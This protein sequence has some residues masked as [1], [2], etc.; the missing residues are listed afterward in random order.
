M[1]D[2][3]KLQ[4]QQEII[5]KLLLQR[6][7][8]TLEAVT[9]FGKTYTAILWYQELCRRA[10][11][12]L[13]LIVVVPYLKLVND[14]LDVGTGHIDRHGLSRGKVTV[15]T[16]NS[17][18]RP[19]AYHTADCFIFD[20]VH[21]YLSDDA[22][23]WNKAIP[24]SRATYRLALSA[25]LTSEEKEKLSLLG[26]PVVDQVT[27]H[28]A[29]QQ[30]YVADYYVFNVPLYLG[31]VDE[32]EYA[33]LDRDFKSG[34]RFFNFDLD[35]IRYCMSFP[36]AMDYARKTHTS[37]EVVRSKAIRSYRAMNARKTFLYNNHTKL[38]MTQQLVQQFPDRRIIVFS[39]SIDFVNRLSDTLGADAVAYHSALMGE[40][41]QGDKLLARARKVKEKGK[42]V[43]RYFELGGKKGYTANELKRMY[44]N[45]TVVGPASVK[46]RAIDRFKRGDARILITATALDEGADI[47][48]IDM[49]IITSATSKKRRTVQRIGRAVR[50]VEGKNSLIVNLYIQGTKDED[51]TTERNKGIQY[52]NVEAADLLQ[53]V[54]KVLHAEDVLTTN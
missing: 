20:E 27:M 19:T 14:W 8:G 15:Y 32:L 54:A 37:V 42:Q 1:I 13:T 16:I 53:E 49:A 17:Y 25:T 2:P 50:F 21:R 46:E 39:Q 52:K 10:G 51:W 43:V 34:F 35:L 4:R 6:G 3:K 24:M 29:L 12:E 33:S 23:E 22:P 9:G 11:K 41:Y 18:L 26:L 47:P 45:V 31:T 38:D 44:H 48:E 5:N 40:I 7:S 28:E 36:G 30:G